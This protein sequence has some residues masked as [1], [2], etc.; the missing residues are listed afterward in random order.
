MENFNETLRLAQKI[1]RG[2][3]INFN[4]KE[5][6]I[7][8]SSIYRFTNEDITSY[9]H[10]LKNK[11]TVLSVIGSGNQILNGILGGTKNFDCFDISI[12]P[13]YY[14]FLQ[15]ASVITLSKED[16]I[17][18]YLSFDNEELFSS[19]FYDKIR[20][21]LKDK[22]K[23]FWDSLYDYDEGIDIYN[24]LL[25]RHDFYKKETVIENNPFLQ[26][27]NYEKLKSILKLEYIKINPIV[28]DIIKTKID[29]K[30]DLIN[31]SN[32][33]S[34]YFNKDNLEEYVNYL[35]TNFNLTNDGEIINYFYA[36]NKEN[37]SKL[38]ELLKSNGYIE[39][40][41]KKKLLIYRNNIN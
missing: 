11:E 31:L 22:Y 1:V 5:T 18:Y 4:N 41:G 27:N 30:Y 36:M 21:N 16:Y 29:K 26:E 17:K 28:L 12:F 38:E 2:S 25:F 9:F 8:T 20:N 6:F 3:Y 35:K 7:D 32:I 15:L 34:Y 23:K 33:L 37:K 13:Q 14:L 19:K 39:D 24:S 40:L 10:H